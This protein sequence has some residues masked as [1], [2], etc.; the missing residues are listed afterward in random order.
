[1]N[2]I[3]KT[4]LSIYGFS[5]LWSNRCTCEHNLTFDSKYPAGIRASESFLVLVRITVEK[6]LSKDCQCNAMAKVVVRSRGSRASYSLTLQ[7]GYLQAE[8]DIP[9]NVVEE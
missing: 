7:S 9:D 3:V 2:T 1:M 8:K 4:H 6:I 5:K